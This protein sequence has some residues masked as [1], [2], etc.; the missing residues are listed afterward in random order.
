M[1]ADMTSWWGK[2][3]SYHYHVHYIFRLGVVVLL[4]SYKSRVS[5]LVDM[6][7]FRKFVTIYQY[8]MSL[9]KY[10]VE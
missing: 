3:L 6:S 9:N 7:K 2:I 5:K 1:V 10:A 4:H 8:Y